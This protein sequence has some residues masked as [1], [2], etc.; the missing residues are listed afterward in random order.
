LTS[1]PGDP[2]TLAGDVFDGFTVKPLY[3]SDVFSTSGKVAEVFDADEQRHPCTRHFT[4]EEAGSPA[5]F[6]LHLLK[7]VLLPAK[8]GGKGSDFIFDGGNTPSNFNNA[9]VGFVSFTFQFED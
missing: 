6:A 1:S 8:I 4:I 2:V 9:S 3:G 5:D 7:M